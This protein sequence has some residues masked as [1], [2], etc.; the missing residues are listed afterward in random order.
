MKRKLILLALCLISTLSFA[1]TKTL[2][3]KTTFSP[4]FQK[5]ESAENIESKL[6]EFGFFA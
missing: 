2:Q 3:T 1:E 4:T 6:N 5:V